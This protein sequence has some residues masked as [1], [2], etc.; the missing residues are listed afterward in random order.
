M[1]K[2]LF[3]F[4][5]LVSTFSMI[6]T[7]CGGGT[8]SGCKEGELPGLT[9]S[10]RPESVIAD[11]S[12]KIAVTVIGK[13]SSCEILPSG[14]L[15]D[16]RLTNQEPANPD[17]DPEQVGAFS[18]GE[19][20]ISVSTSNLGARVDLTSVVPGS[21]NVTA[22]A[23][24]DGQYMSAIPVKVEF[25]DAPQDR[26]GISLEA[27]PP[28][29]KADGSASTT[30]SATVTAYDGAPV[31]DGTE[32]NFTT[33]L[34]AFSGVNDTNTTANTLGG[35]ATVSLRSEELTETQIAEVTATFICN[36]PNKSEKSNQQS[37][38]FTVGAD[39]P[40]L[41][42]SKDKNEVLADGNSY[43]TLTAEVFLP[44]GSRAG[45][46]ETVSFITDL[47]KFAEADAGTPT[48][49]DG[50]TD[51]DGKAIV[52]FI[53]GTTGGLATI[54][55]SIYIQDYNASAETQINVRQ[56]GFVEFI[57][58]DPEKLGVRGSGV[59]ETSR[60]S[61]AVKDTDGEAFANVL[62]NFSLSTA[63]G[64]TL[65]PLQG[66]TD[67][68][69]LVYTT[70]KSGNIATSV[71]VTATA[72]V[73]DVELEATSPALAI[74]GAKPN[75]R[76][77]TFSCERFNV[78]GFILDDVHTKCTVLLSDRYSNK[79]GFATSV[80]FMTE[81]GQITSNATTADSGDNMGSASVTIRTGNPRPKDV[82]PLSDPFEPSVVDGNY[83]RNPRD[84]LLI[85]IAATTGEEEFTDV[86][87][88]GDYDE[89][90]PFVDMGEPLIDADDNGIFTPGEQ[91]L[92]ANGNSAYDGPNGQWDGDTIIWT[93]TWMVWSGHYQPGAACGPYSALCPDTFNIPKGSTQSFTWKVTD[94]NLNPLNETLNVSMSVDGKGSLGSTNPHL[95]YN[96]NDV[97]GTAISM[98]KVNNVDSRTPCT[99]SDPICY[100][101][102]IVSGFT[103]GYT[104]EAI[105]EGASVTDTNPPETGTVSLTATYK[106]TPGAGNSI[107]AGD[108][109]TGTFQ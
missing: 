87:G 64:V 12:S 79:V 40:F 32:V 34:G 43:A 106:E 31:A 70:L 11:G 107:S 28:S 23:T 30:I 52:T 63:P 26:C 55:A 44:D 51:A 22:S 10:V 37:V 19:T 108:I 77:I 69:G 100:V 101:V 73:G 60:L 81:A 105:V 65:E 39:K 9:L 6:L 78:G 93:A 85:I 41:T 42:L 89:G 47:G 7:G 36:D 95:P 53:G 25:T 46:G 83:V 5:I 35:V 104:G 56:V 62:V 86:N 17:D 1:K 15:I 3:M 71:T 96:A 92:D 91:F 16:L 66:R 76:G 67:N 98:V 21:A 18:N 103:G 72:V 99:D 13:N 61:F 59:N 29:I 48:V 4:A 27:D 94:F 90:E 97:L 14:T 88:N 109:V 54:R 2:A 68:D 33:T 24:I 57:K 75:A 102:P 49:Y 50:T 45:A 58:A 38:P 20:S 8:G 80:T 84:G 74:V 82:D